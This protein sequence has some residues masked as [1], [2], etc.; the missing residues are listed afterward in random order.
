M[1]LYAIL[2]KKKKTRNNKDLEKIQ[3][4][5]VSHPSIRYIK[6]VTSDTFSF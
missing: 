1:F 3:E 6:K 2:K 5:F 4:T